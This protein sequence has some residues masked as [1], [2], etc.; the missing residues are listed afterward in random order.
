[1]KRVFI[2]SLG[3]RESVEAEYTFF[4]D[5]SLGFVL[6]DCIPVSI[7][8]TPDAPTPLLRL[9]SNGLIRINEIRFSQVLHAMFECKSFAE[10]ESS[11]QLDADQQWPQ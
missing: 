7:T 1:M 10:S 6:L 8:K 4:N 9:L 5:S 11:F 2:G 3:N